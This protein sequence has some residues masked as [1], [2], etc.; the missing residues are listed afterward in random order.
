MTYL[1]KEQQK[2][3]RLKIRKAYK[4]ILK[5]H[6]SL[7]GLEGINNI[8]ENEIWHRLGGKKAF[9]GHFPSNLY[10]IIREEII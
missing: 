1:N 6:P 10:Q 9:G 2:I 5:E 8:F 3:V 7:H 4:N